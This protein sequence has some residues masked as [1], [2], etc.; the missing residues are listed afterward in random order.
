MEEK[1]EF[2]KL[3]E[4]DR[5]VLIWLM[6][7]VPPKSIKSWIDFIADDYKRQRAIIIDARKL[8]METQEK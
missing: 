1:P 7:H 8:F 3:D 5:R 6:I 4:I 2:F